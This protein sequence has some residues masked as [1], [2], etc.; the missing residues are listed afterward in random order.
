M[1]GVEAQLNELLP[2]IKEVNPILREW[3]KLAFIGTLMGF[4]ERGLL[5][6]DPNH[7]YIYSS[8]IEDV[9]KMFDHLQE[10]GGDLES[11]FL[12]YQIY[13][14]GVQWVYYLDWSLYLSQEL[15]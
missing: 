10:A 2:L 1:K 11:D 13:D 15:Y 5:S 12:K 4:M 6:Q 9:R 7:Q 8:I 14:Y 3:L